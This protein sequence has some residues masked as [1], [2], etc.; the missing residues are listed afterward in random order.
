MAILFP[1]VLLTFSHY[2]R[3]TS[4]LNWVFSLVF[5][6]RKQ[7][8]WWDGSVAKGSMP[9]STWWRESTDPKVVL[10]PSRPYFGTQAPTLPHKN[11]VIIFLKR[12]GVVHPLCS[13]GRHSI[14]DSSAFTSWMLGLQLYAE[15]WIRP[16]YTIGH[17]G[18]QPSCVCSP[19]AVSKS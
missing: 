11:N 2:G 4:V 19:T 3:I 7:N 8:S 16:S 14:S 13:W 1:C 12:R 6:T 17:V 5:P 10:W 9:G 15:N 18:W